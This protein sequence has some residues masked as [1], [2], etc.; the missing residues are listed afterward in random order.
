MIERMAADCRVA[1]VLNGVVAPPRIVVDVGA[2]QALQET[3]IE[4]EDVPEM[5]ARAMRGEVR[6][7]SWCRRCRPG[8]LPVEVPGAAS[9]R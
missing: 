7:A 3:P 6:V 5:S 2:L 1:A 9:G 4:L 8:R